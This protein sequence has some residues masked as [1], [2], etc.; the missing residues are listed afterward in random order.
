MQLHEARTNQDQ[1]TADQLAQELGLPSREEHE[2]RKERREE[3]REQRKDPKEEDGIEPNGQEIENQVIEN[4]ENTKEDKPSFTKNVRG[5]F[6]R[7]FR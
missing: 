5:F 3:T 4:Q 1:E 7:F 2:E 6:G